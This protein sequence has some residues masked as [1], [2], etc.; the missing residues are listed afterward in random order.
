MYARNEE[1]KNPEFSVKYNFMYKIFLLCPTS[2]LHSDGCK[3]T[4]IVFREA[5]FLKS[6]VN[7]IIIVAKVMRLPFSWSF[8]ETETYF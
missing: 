7:T 4:S 6:S 2:D 3:P 8:R 5:L 1:N